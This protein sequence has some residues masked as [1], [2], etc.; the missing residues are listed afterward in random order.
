M[1][2]PGDVFEVLPSGYKF[3]VAHIYGQVEAESAVLPIIVSFFELVASFGLFAAILISAWNTRNSTNERL[4]VRTRVA[5]FLTPLLFCQVLSAIGQIIGIAWISRMGVF[6]G[7]LCTAQAIIKH[8]SDVAIALFNITIAIHSFGTLWRWSR[9]QVKVTKPKQELVVWFGRPIPHKEFVKWLLFASVWA[10]IVLIF[11]L[12]PAIGS[13]GHNGDFYGVWGEWCYVTDG[14][15]GER[16]AFGYA[17]MI[18]SATISIC[19]FCAT[20]FSVLRAMQV[21]LMDA[22]DGKFENIPA[23]NEEYAV[24]LAKFMIWF[25]LVYF[26]CVLPVIIVR[27]IYWAGV[28]IPFGATVFTD[29]IY[30]LLGI[31]DTVLFVSTPGLLPPESLEVLQFW[32]PRPD[33][34][35]SVTSI[36]ATGSWLRELKN[37][38]ETVE[39][40]DRRPAPL[41]LGA[42]TTSSLR[43]PAAPPPL[44]VDEFKPQGNAGKRGDTDSDASTPL[45]MLRGRVK[46]R[47]SAL[48]EQQRA[49]SAG[50]GES[51]PRHISRRPVPAYWELENWVEQREGAERQIIVHSAGSSPPHSAQ[52]VTDVAEPAMKRCSSASVIEMRPAVPQGVH[53]AV[54]RRVR[55]DLA[56]QSPAAGDSATSVGSYFAGAQAEALATRIVPHVERSLDFPSSA[57]HTITA[58]MTTVSSSKGHAEKQELREID[59]N[60][61]EI[62]WE[63]RE[64]VEGSGEWECI[65]K[66]RASTTSQ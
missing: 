16:V 61:L 21:R 42:S 33:S 8:F 20:V 31:L 6:M 38:P 14:Y 4:F 60:D 23:E 32:K 59:V 53:L 48:H 2:T 50:S 39:D 44:Y 11:T 34:S 43:D 57:I 56:A 37:F 54:P 27:F 22:E 41:N 47:K 28:S 29:A 52:A 5:A 46:A 49:A 51:Q 45:S 30:H 65:E 63:C 62:E 12:G 24:M 3:V 10:I 36:L 40:R 15:L 66:I 18:L 35:Q 19:L 26:C 58:E 1:I 17:F 64:V 13:T 25:P 7:G 9:P 55:F